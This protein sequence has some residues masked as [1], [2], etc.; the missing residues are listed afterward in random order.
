MPSLLRI[1]SIIMGVTL[2]ATEFT[3]LPEPESVFSIGEVSKW[4]VTSVDGE[5]VGAAWRSEVNEDDFDLPVIFRR[6]EGT[7]YPLMESVPEIL[8]NAPASAGIKRI[9]DDGCFA[10]GGFFDL[11]TGGS[12]YALWDLEHPGTFV[13]P[14]EEL[15]LTDTRPVGMSGDAEVILCAGLRS[16]SSSGEIWLWKRSS[17]TFER[18]FAPQD[19]SGYAFIQFG[20]RS[21]SRSGEQ[22]VAYIFGDDLNGCVVWDRG[23]SRVLPKP[24]RTNHCFP[25]AIS[26]NGK[27]VVGFVG[28]LSGGSSR[29]RFCRLSSDGESAELFGPIWPDNR[30]PHLY[31]TNSGRYALFWSA[32]EAYEE[33]MTVVYDFWEDRTLALTDLFAAHG[34]FPLIDTAHFSV[35]DFRENENGFA[36]CGSYQIQSGAEKLFVF[37]AEGPFFPVGDPRIE[38]ESVDDYTVRFS[39]KDAN[40]DDRRS[41]EISDDLVSWRTIDADEFF[42]KGEGLKVY[43]YGEEERASFYRMTTVKSGD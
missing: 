32:K 26:D 27:W 12:R 38:L 13:T 35:T 2:W 31:I 39:I 5:I 10:F 41:Y 42:K 30:I 6:G 15:E 34:V 28:N 7:Y 18:I 25:L 16:G 21:M 3:T 22:F 4:C 17:N 14:W 29:L 40:P 9:S 19:E 24:D 43:F 33:V 23:E 20:F 36:L 11:S 1:V 37:S 8:E